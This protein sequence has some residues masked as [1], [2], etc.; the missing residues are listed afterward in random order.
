MTCEVKT[1]VKPLGREL[2]YG[3]IICIKGGISE[4]ASPRSSPGKEPN[5]DLTVHHQRHGN[6]YYAYH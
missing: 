5:Y 1:S 4:L 6:E 3:N 2:F